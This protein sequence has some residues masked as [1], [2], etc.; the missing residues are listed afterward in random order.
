MEKKVAELDHLQSEIKRFRPW[1]DHPFRSL[2]ILRQV[3]QAF[4][5]EGRISA[6][7]L[8]IRELTGVTITGVADDNQVFLE[9]LGRLSSDK[10]VSDLK[11]DSL[12]GKAPMQFTFN[13]NWVDQRD[14]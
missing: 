1:F 6:K 8:E 9:T 11:T 3:A 14:R 4:P 10:N 5:E 2:V 12:K 7:S 13:F